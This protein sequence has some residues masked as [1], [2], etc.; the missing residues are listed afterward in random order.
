[1]PPLPPPRY[2]DP[3]TPDAL[4]FDLDGTLW[5]AA[6]AS[7]FGWNLALEE[8]GLPHRVTADDI[9]SVSGR[10]FP[11]CVSTLLPDLVPWPADLQEHLEAR[12]RTGIERI[13]GDL[14]PG[15]SEGLRRLAARYPLFLVSNCPGWYL[16]EFFRR[17]G[18]RDCF[19][20]WDCHGLSGIAKSGMLLNLAASHCLA[21]AVYVGDTRGDQSSAEAAGMEFVF[22]SYGFGAP[23]GEPLAFGEFEELV[24]HYLG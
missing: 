4:I 10:P 14:Y 5:D 23:E 12:E 21:N 7:T 11:E 15:V 6:A 22:A 24:A 9:R 13:S 18:L 16:D 3:V 1:V 19:T 17:S 2:H 8:R 20:G